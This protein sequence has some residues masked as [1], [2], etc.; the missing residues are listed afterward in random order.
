MNERCP[1]AAAATGCWQGRG[2]QA[3]FWPASLS[4][5][6]PLLPLCA[7]GGGAAACRLSRTTA[8]HIST[9]NHPPSPPLLPPPLVCRRRWRCRTPT[10]WATCC[11][12]QRAL[13]SAASCSPTSPPRPRPWA[14]CRRGRRHR[15]WAG[16]Q[17]WWGKRHPGPAAPLL[18]SICLQGL[19]AWSAVGQPCQR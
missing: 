13:A 8:H 5:S 18:P 15:R 17:V 6:Q 4:A 2:S 16:Q 9:A 1:T 11:P 10:L 7:G 3:R 12:S 19:P 14:R